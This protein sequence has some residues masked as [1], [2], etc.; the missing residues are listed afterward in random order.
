[1]PSEPTGNEPQNGAT[2]AEPETPE[3]NGTVN[4]QAAPAAEEPDVE[5]LKEWWQQ[6]QKWKAANDA[7]AAQLKREKREFEEERAKAEIEMA[8]LLA[9]PDYWRTRREEMREL[10]E[11]HGI[12]VRDPEMGQ[13]GTSSEYESPEIAKLAKEIRAIRQELGGVLQVQNLVKQTVEKTE[14]ERQFPHI[15]KNPRAMEL[16]EEL[17]RVSGNTYAAAAF[18]AQ[19][20]EALAPAQQKP[21]P[22]KQVPPVATSGGTVP[23]REPEKKGEYGTDEFTRSGVNLLRDIMSNR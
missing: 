16:V 17:G 12:E 4:E 14:V 5:T 19:L 13:I 1:M 2:P 8:K 11:T 6:N 9:D 23:V 20:A 22:P 3:A 7:R 15:A 21:Q 18:A 10:L